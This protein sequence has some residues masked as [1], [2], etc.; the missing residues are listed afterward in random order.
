V[1][2]KNVYNLIYEKTLADINPQYQNLD[3]VFMEYE[4]DIP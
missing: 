2:S 4:E 1:K 3:K